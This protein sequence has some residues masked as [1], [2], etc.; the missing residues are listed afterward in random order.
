[1]LP[2]TLIYFQKSFSFSRGILSNRIPIN[3]ICYIESKCQFK[4]LWPLDMKLSTIEWNVGSEN[5]F[6]K[7]FLTLYSLGVNFLCLEIVLRT[8][9]VCSR[10]SGEDR[11]FITT[12][13][14]LPA[15]PCLPSKPLKAGQ[16]KLIIFHLL[17]C[18]VLI[19]IYSFLFPV[20]DLRTI[21]R[22]LG[23]RVV[24]Q[25]I[26]KFRTEHNIQGVPKKWGISECYSVCFT[27]HFLWSLEY[28]FLI[29][30][31]IEIHMFVPSKKTFLSNIR[32]QRNIFSIIG[33]MCS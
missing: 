1:M 8:R 11:S 19:S 25:M 31:K 17:D 23:G 14:P 6:F 26:S 18:L 21:N 3:I 32:E 28:S 13:C 27:A 16:C 30:L 2:F 5:H 20:W 10:V 12:T 7:T 33:I 29:H 15:S 24:G 22:G 4:N 9:R